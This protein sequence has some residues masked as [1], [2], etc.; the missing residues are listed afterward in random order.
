MDRPD[1]W[2]A[3]AAIVRD[4]LHGRFIQFADK[5]LSDVSSGFVVLAIDCLLIETIQQFID[6]ITDGSG[7]STFLCKKFLEGPRFQLYFDTNQKR[8]DFYTDIR[9]GLL[10]SAEAKKEWRVRRDRP[11]MLATI[12]NGYVIN[13][14]LFHSA[15][16]ASLDDYLRDICITERAELRVK[17]WTKMDHICNLREQRGAVEETEAVTAK[18]TA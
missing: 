4:R 7:Q 9:C 15:L 14:L 16:K 12:G 8:H 6:G 3:A 11:E 17:L 5:C 1:D 2:P 13:V 18:L 10:H